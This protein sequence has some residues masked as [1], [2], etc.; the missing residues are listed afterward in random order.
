[1]STFTIPFRLNQFRRQYPDRPPPGRDCPP[2]YNR[3]PLRCDMSLSQN[4]RISSFKYKYH[5]DENSKRRE[6]QRQIIK[7]RLDIF[8]DLFNT[9]Y[10]NNLSVDIENQC[11]LIKFLDVG[12]ILK[13]L[14][15]FCRNFSPQLKKNHTCKTRTVVSSIQLFKA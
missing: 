7:K 8:M 14:I 2:R 15:R 11:E 1:M 10:P 13:Y 3:T 6:E 9:D 4:K 5:L 12:I